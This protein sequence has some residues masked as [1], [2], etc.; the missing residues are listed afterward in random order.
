MKHLLCVGGNCAD[1]S[2]RAAYKYAPANDKLAIPSSKTSLHSCY[3]VP[4]VSLIRTLPYALR[5]LL[6]PQTFQNVRTSSM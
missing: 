3:I 4:N 5:N 6:F 2:T 1:V